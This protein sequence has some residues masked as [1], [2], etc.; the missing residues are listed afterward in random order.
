[1]RGRPSTLARAAALLGCG[2]LAVLLLLPGRAPATRSDRMP[3]PSLLPA[4][5]AGDV[6]VLQLPRPV[7]PPV[8]H[9][10]APPPA[11]V[12]PLTAGVRVHRL[13]VPPPLPPRVHRLHVIP[14]TLALTPFEPARIPSDAPPRLYEPS[15]ATGR[16]MGAPRLLTPGALPDGL[17][18]HYDDAY[19]GWPVAPLHASHL[20]HGDF[21]DPRE[22]GYHFGVDIPVDDSKPA[23]QAPPGMSHRIFAVESG[24]L[25]YTRHGEMSLNCNDRRFQ[26]GHFSYWHAS[27]GWPEGTYVHAGDMIG[28]TCLNE[29]HVHLSEW[30]LVNGQRT[31]V[32][33]LHA[34]GKLRPYVDT[35]APVIR[36]LYAYGPPAASWAPRAGG[37]LAA[38]DGALTLSFGNLRGAVDLRAWIDDSQGGTGR[39]GASPPLA[40]DISPYR[41]WVQIRRPADG[42]IVWQRTSWQSDMLLTGRQRLYAHFATRSRPPLSDYLC[43]ETAGACSGRLFY[44]LL[45]S[46]DRYLWDT[47]SVRDG[48]YTLT[49]RASDIGGNVGTRS[50]PLSVRNAD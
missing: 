35:S 45:V 19:T 47:R 7:L 14:P 30:A 39:D 28:W 38:S 41:I 21:N 11:R 49:V 44:H 26:A 8:G 15:P 20:L 13:L 40:A 37:E 36:A 9:A 18:F 31:W 5:R 3:V 50:V 46:D 17:R 27:P 48:T 1:M 22:G 10:L 33:P 32:N 43:A 25:H 2:L 34:G 4:P 29:W 16:R 6:P 23:L 42:A 24:V 12:S